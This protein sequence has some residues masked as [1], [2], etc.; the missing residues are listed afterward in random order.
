MTAFGWSNQAPPQNTMPMSPSA[1]EAQPTQL[2]AERCSFKKIAEQ[3]TLKKSTPALSK[4]KSRVVFMPLL[5]RV[6]RRMI[7]EEV[8]SEHSI[9]NRKELPDCLK[10]KRKFFLRRINPNAKLIRPDIPNVQM[11]SSFLEWTVAS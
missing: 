9:K 6:A 1:I 10:S 2:S 4:V 7:A 11:I 8:Q 5:I 3:T